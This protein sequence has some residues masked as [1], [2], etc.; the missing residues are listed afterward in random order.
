MEGSEVAAS[1][2]TYV[3]RLGVTLLFVALNG[4]FVAAEFAL[5]KVRVSRIEGLADTGNRR[6]GVA[7][8]LVENLDFY[9]SAC[10]LGNTLASLILGWLAEPAVAQILLLG[11][12]A[13]GWEHVFSPAVTHAIALMLALTVVTILHMTIG[14]QA[15]K[16]WAIRRADSTVL[17]IAY[18][19]RV[20]A[21]L[22]APFIW[23]I[24]EISMWLLRLAGMTSEEHG[25]GTHNVDEICTILVTSAEAGHLSNR[26]LQLAENVLHLVDLE[27]RHIFV[28]RVDVVSL[29]LARPLEENLEVVRDTSHTRFPVCETDLDSVVGIVHVKDVATATLSGQDIDLRVL[30]RKPV[31][32]SDTQPLAGLIAEMQVKRAHSAVVLDEHGSVLGL[33]FLEDAIEHVVGTIRD[34]FDEVT[35][36]PHQETDGSLHVPGGYPLPQAIEQLGL[37]ELDDAADTIG[38]YVTSRLG[39]LPTE[40]DEL[41]IGSYR[42]TVAKVARRRVAWLSFRNAEAVEAAEA[43]EATPSDA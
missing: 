8:Y 35:P 6:A 33:V 24:N 37:P 15:P 28:P 2:W 10:Q 26:Q 3:L 4:F 13:L 34:E 36:A 21:A 16:I 14:E 12:A 43:G 23:V 42:V 30:A 27:V 19:L 18:P 32:V 39:R 9:L 31:F 11:V 22:L 38:G 41:D 29:S 17:N 1:S 25:E 7:Q 40:G 20:F 5:V